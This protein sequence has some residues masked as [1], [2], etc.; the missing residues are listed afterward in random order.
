MNEERLLAVIDVGTSKVC[1]LVALLREDE[2]D[3]EVIGVGL[4]PSRGLRRGLVVDIQS[5]AEAIRASVEEAERSSGYRIRSALVGI[6]GSHI[7]SSLSR[8][9]VA[10]TRRDHLITQE[11][12]D[13]AVS[14]A[15]MVNVAGHQEILHVIPRNFTLDGQDG[16]HHPVGMHGFR[17]EVEAVIVTVASDPLRNLLLA[18]RHVDL[19]ESDFV[20]H[21][22]ASGEAVLTEEEKE[23]GVL[24]ADI[25][26]GTTD[27]AVFREGGLAHT[28]VLP[29]GGSHV[30]NDLGTLLYLPPARAEQIKERYGSALPDNLE[31]NETIWVDG[32]G[33]EG[34]RPLS[35]R[36]VAEIVHARMEEIF[37]LVR[38]RMEHAGYDERLPAGLVLT[39]GTAN[40]RGVDALARQ[41][42]GWPVRIG[43]PFGV[44]GLVEEL[45]DPTFATAVGLLLWAVRYG[46][47]DSAHE[48]RRPWLEP[49]HRAWQ[50]VRSLLP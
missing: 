27:L 40:L 17:L 32:F 47:W 5:A 7:E 43:V 12:V 8:G 13:R 4:T 14:N 42:T 3:P 24:V 15:G 50:W 29:L 26:G 19:R 35:R 30:T 10:V 31:E 46:S 36:R 45:R 49:V 39:G 21:A 11:D 18:L 20:L 48:L 28:Q 6:T 23:M 33:S 41:I 38:Q 1:T 16:I 2:E 25:G 37:R 9:M 22:W 34:E 44:Q